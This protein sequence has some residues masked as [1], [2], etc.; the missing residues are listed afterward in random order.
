MSDKMYLNNQFIGPT[1]CTPLPHSFISVLPVSYHIGD[2][3]ERFRL[4]PSPLHQAGNVQVRVTLRLTVSQSVCL[5]VEPSY[6][7]FDHRLFIFFFLKVTVL[8]FWG[9]PL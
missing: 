8:S 1:I 7:T 3:A 5:G 4:A 2:I 9:R 6:G